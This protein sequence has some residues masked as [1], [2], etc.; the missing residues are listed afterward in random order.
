MA[1][2]KPSWLSRMLGFGRDKVSAARPAAATLNGHCVLASGQ[3]VTA[4]EWR[5]GETL[6]DDFLV[7]GLL[8]EGGMGKVYLVRSRS[9]R[10]AFAVKRARALDDLAR[11]NF[12]AELQ[13]WI[14]L[15][16]H[17]NLVPC[18]FFRSLSA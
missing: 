5:A 15:P 16:D 10:Q 3:S 12:L 6:L 8:G 11:R 4:G 13:T 17:P 2:E 18:R 9:S 14:D 7:E 1:K